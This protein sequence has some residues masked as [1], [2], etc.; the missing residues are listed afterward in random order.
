MPAPELG[1][2]LA[3]YMAETEILK[4]I[5]G[6]WAGLTVDAV[7]FV[8][9]RNS[10]GFNYNKLASLLLQG[11]L[12]Y[13]AIALKEE[14]QLALVRCFRFCSGRSDRL[15][16]HFIVYSRKAVIAN[17]TYS[18]QAGLQRVL[19]RRL[20]RSSS[21]SM[22]Q[23]YALIVRHGYFGQMKKV[24]YVQDISSASLG[25]MMYTLFWER[26]F[27][28]G[29]FGWYSVIVSSPVASCM[30]QTGNFLWR[31][32]GRKK[33]HS[34]TNALKERFMKSLLS[35]SYEMPSH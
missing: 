24:S 27:T 14:I 28:R 23:I 11:R 12:L 20:S 34:G 6:L 7:S 30:P 1:R 21:F 2:Q 26:P 25:C 32:N 8:S 16:F 5:R 17:C 3:V 9:V 31:A 19:V 22:K 15:A 29:R 18:A 13:V 10:G 33:Y 4:V 35:R